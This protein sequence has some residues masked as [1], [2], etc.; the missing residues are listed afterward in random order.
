MSQQFYSWVYIQKKTRNHK[1]KKTHA[2][3]G[4]RSTVYNFH[5]LEVTLVSINR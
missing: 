3:N 1:F 2:P 4:H 5:A